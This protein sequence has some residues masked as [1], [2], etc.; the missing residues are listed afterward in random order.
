MNEVAE[1]WDDFA[2]EYYQIQKESQVPIVTDIEKFL[3]EQRLLPT[4]SVVDLGGGSGR[5][6]PALAQNSQQYTIV[7]ISEQMLRYAQ[8]ENQALAKPRSVTYQQQSVADFS[9]QTPDQSYDL[10]WMALNPAV[11]ADETLLTIT[12]KSRQWCGFLR[13]TQ[14]IDDL[15]ASLEQYFEIA[16]EN[17]NIE[18]T[19]I[20]AV[21]KLLTSAGYQVRQQKFQYQT[22]ETFDRVFLEAYYA[23]VPKALLSTYLDQVFA[24]QKTRTSTTTLEYTLLY[25]HV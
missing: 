11:T 22:T 6:L 10:V 19:I 25:W 17:P 20:P 5:Y 15:F 23:E 24:N 4:N 1:F 7:D 3:T 2:A 18:S 9:Q 16:E 13:L 12:Q 8:V 14:N 21:V